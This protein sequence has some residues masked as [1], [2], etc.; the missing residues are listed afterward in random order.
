MT[1]S[2]EIP[3]CMIFLRSHYVT[4]LLECECWD[5]NINFLRRITISVREL[6]LRWHT[7]SIELWTRSK[8]SHAQ[9]WC[10]K[11][12][13]LDLPYLLAKSGGLLSGRLKQSCQTNVNIFR[14]EC[15]HPS[16][17]WSIP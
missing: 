7:D 5:R 2:P 10:K 14:G 11:V 16:I 4:K 12:V 15:E 1:I 17:S 6:T 3:V 9:S 13:L 8:A